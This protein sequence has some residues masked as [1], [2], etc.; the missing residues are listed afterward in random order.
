MGDRYEIYPELNFGIAKLEPGIK[1]FDTLFKVAKEF[2]EDPNFSKVHYQLTDMRGCSFDF[3]ISRLANMASLIDE[4]Q[5]Y[6]NQKLGVYVIDKPLGTAYVQ[7]FFDSLKY[8]R[9]FC[10]TIEKAYSLLGLKIPFKEFKKLI[11]I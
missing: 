11:A 9:E 7:L 4:F 1:S 8:N 2:R 5:E 3:D 6:D 10:S